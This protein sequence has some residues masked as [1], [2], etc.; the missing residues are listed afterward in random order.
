MC[1][2][3]LSILLFPSLITPSISSTVFCILHLSS[4]FLFIFLFLIPDSLFTIFFLTC[5]FLFCLLFSLLSGLSHYCLSLSCL[6]LSFCFL[7]SP[8]LPIS[9][10]I[11]PFAVLHSFFV[12]FTC[13]RFLALTSF[14]CSCSLFLLLSF[15]S[16]SF[17]SYHA[18]RLLS[19]IL[20]FYFLL[21]HPIFLSL[22]S[23]LP[24]PA[25]CQFLII[26]ILV[27][28]CPSF[29]L[30][31]FSLTSLLSSSLTLTPL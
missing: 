6:L 2:D 10:F 5:S 1:C 19:F 12:A 16:R 8:Y 14:F 21:F 30:A 26:F 23:L 15:T 9:L 17:S 18:L 25:S 31:S 28:T 20:F 27:H 7:S 24:L 11:H 3:S 13:V 29:V 22:I 4:P